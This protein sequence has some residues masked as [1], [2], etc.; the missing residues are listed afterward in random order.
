[1]TNL[2]HENIKLSFDIASLLP[3]L[4][5]SRDRAALLELMEPRE[6]DPAA[7]EWVL[8]KLASHALLLC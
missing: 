2:R 3:L 1:V 7:L 6:R 4:D 8:D 5:G